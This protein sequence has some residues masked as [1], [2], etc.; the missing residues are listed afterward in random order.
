VLNYWRPEESVQ[1]L[2]LNEV[3]VFS[4]VRGFLFWIIWVTESYAGVYS[5]L[6]LSLNIL[7]TMTM[8]LAAKVNPA[9]MMITST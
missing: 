3:T 8:S 1:W 2:E 7:Q 4:F 9:M 6:L 5:V